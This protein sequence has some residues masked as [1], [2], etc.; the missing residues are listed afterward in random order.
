MNVCELIN[1]NSKDPNML[2]IREAVGKIYVRK[3]RKAAT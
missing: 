3:F 1:N 2:M